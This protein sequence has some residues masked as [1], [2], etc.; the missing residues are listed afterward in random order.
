MEE[1]HLEK[2]GNAMTETMRATS[3][4]DIDERDFTFDGAALPDVLAQYGLASRCGSGVK[5][6]MS[7]VFE[8]AIRCFMS[9]DDEVRNEAEGWI[10]SNERGFVFAFLTIC[11]ALEL[12]GGAVRE[13][14]TATRHRDGFVA[15]RA[16]R[17][18]PNVRRHQPLRPN[19]RR[20][21]NRP[22]AP[23]L[24]EPMREAASA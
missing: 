8:D 16:I 2:R 6:L 4:G 19:R 24:D 18:R 3:F 11:D 7:A 1:Y 20:N 22:S 21:R 13:A 5:A 23:P 17:T 10:E 9:P 12:D 15:R 14:L